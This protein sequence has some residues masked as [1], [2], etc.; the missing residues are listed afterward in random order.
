MRIITEDYESGGHSL[1]G[2]PNRQS[3]L[4]NLD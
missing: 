4:G 2:F 3:E 1:S